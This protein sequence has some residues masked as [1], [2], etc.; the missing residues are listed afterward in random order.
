MSEPQ[1]LRFQ[2]LVDPKTDRRVRDVVAFG[3]FELA[4]ENQAG[5]VYS[6]HDLPRFF[7]DLI[8]GRPLPLTFVTRSV[9]SVSTVVAVALFLKRELAI[10][11]V[12]PNLVTAVALAEQLQHAGLAHV[13]RDLARFFRLLIGYLPETLTR[14]DQQER[15]TT[16]VSWIYQYIVEGVLP[17][18]PAEPPVPRVLDHGADGFVVAEVPSKA[19]DLGWVEL[20]RMGFLRGVLFG[21]TQENRTHVLAARKGPFQRLDLLQAAAV[22]NEAEGALGEPQTWAVDGTWLRSPVGGTLL[23]HAAVVNVLIRV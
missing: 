6:N 22:L 11:P 3:A 15:L 18:L 10:H 7:S 5:V 9:T 23:S 13:E 17:G 19:L 2:V 20:F 1:E 21:P 14:K 4:T 16:A 12:T 8:L